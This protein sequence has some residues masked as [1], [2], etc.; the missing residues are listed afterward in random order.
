MNAEMLLAL[1]GEIHR[2]R[3]RAAAAIRAARRARRR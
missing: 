1:A 2:D 3:V